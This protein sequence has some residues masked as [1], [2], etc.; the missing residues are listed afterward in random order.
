MIRVRVLVQT[1][2]V[3]L[4]LQEFRLKPCEVAWGQRPTQA[5]ALTSRGSRYGQANRKVRKGGKERERECWRPVLW[6]TRWE[7]MTTFSPAN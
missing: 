3:S 4:I 7:G 5:L 6:R 2:G 1:W